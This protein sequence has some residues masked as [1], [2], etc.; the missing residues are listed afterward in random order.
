MIQ[1]ILN[2]RSLV[3]NYYDLQDDPSTMRFNH[4][5]DRNYV[6]MKL[7]TNCLVIIEFILILLPERPLDKH[8]HNTDGRNRRNQPEKINISRRFVD[9]KYLDQCPLNNASVL[10]RLLFG[11][12]TNIIWNTFRRPPLKYDH[13]WSL[14]PD[15]WSIVNAARFSKN[16]LIKRIK[17]NIGNNDQYRFVTNGLMWPL[18]KTFWPSILFNAFLKL[19]SS[20]LPYLNALFLS[21][22]IK[23]LEQNIKHREPLW[24]GI[25]YVVLMLFTPILDTLIHVQYN[26]QINI[27]LLKVKASLC[28]VIYRK[29]SQFFYYLTPMTRKCVFGSNGEIHWLLW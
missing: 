23:Y 1:V 26:F 14:I 13:L 19:C 25:V 11:W 18:V 16:F 28:D 7:F 5:Q 12:T 9:M 15:H 20:F 10:S 2:T 4:Y 21:W 6:G 22:L 27:I 29:V 8:L 3:F 24:H 17:S